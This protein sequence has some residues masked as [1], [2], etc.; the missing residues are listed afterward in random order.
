MID[1]IVKLGGAAL[2]DKKF[3]EKEKPEALL[4]AS[5]VLANCASNGLKFIILHG[6]G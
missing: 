1:F 5:G 6:A 4:K 3:I 2:S